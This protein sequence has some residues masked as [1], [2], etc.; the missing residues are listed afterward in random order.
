MKKLTFFT[1][2]FSIFLLSGC[3]EDDSNQN[4]DYF[5]SGKINGDSFNFGLNLNDEYA[6]Y[7]VVDSYYGGGSPNGCDITYAPGIYPSYDESLAEFDI[8]FN[9][10]Y[11][12][13]CDD[14]QT[15]LNSD[16]FAVGTYQIG[17]TAGKVNL[18]Y[19]PNADE[20]VVYLS[21]IGAQSNASFKITSSRQVN[22]MIFQYVYY[23][24]EIEG[25]FSARLYNSDDVSD[26]IDV[27]NGKFRLLVSA[28]NN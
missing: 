17:G 14:E 12:G 24:Q 13:N 16:T 20:D 1:F 8:E 21:D 6:D 28:Y 15:S 2:I 9:N 22:Q 19:L 27:T 7:V 5:I 4:F 25:T 10:F 26:Y 18:I 3:Q 11:I 23:M